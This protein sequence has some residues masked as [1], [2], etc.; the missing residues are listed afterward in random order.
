M[1]GILFFSLPYLYS[2]PNLSDIHRIIKVK[3]GKEL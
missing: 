1:E 3:V 2:M